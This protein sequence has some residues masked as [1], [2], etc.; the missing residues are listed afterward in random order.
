MGDTAILDQAALDSLRDMTGGDPSFL[1]ELIDT[2]F[3]D[4][5]DQFASMRQA[6]AANDSETLRRAAHSLKSNSSTFGALGL[7]D[8]CQE[9]ESRA[10]NDQLE[11]IDD[12]INQSAVEYERVHAV[13]DLLRQDG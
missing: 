12:L 13:L 11:G 5:I 10:R 1:A 9:I 2:F 7:A 8:I 6:A 4:S 3:S